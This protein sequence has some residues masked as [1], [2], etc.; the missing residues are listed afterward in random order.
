MATNR[1]GHRPG[2]GI[3]SRQHVKTPVRTGSGSKSTNP[4]AVAQLGQSQGNH[5]TNKSETNYRGEIF[6]KPPNFQPVKFGNEVALNVGKGGCGTGRETMPRG[7][8]GQHG[9]PAPGNP[10]AKNVDILSGYGPESKRS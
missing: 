5:I 3:A 4:G 9:A 1:S 8:Q 2:G 7:S 10:P 6:H